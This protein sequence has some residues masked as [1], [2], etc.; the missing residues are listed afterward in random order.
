MMG[1][2]LDCN[3]G[4]ML[5]TGE[6]DNWDIHAPPGIIEQLGIG[7][8]QSY[9]EVLLKPLLTLNATIRT[10]FGEML[11]HWVDGVLGHVETPYEDL[12][13]LYGQ[14]KQSGFKIY[15]TSNFEKSENVSLE[16]L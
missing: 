7:P 15:Y 3:N 1:K 14:L 4:S 2:N 16:P 11:H 5:N 8:I 10:H 9:S 13:D 6:L 12:T